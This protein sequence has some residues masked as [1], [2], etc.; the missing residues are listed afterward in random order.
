MGFNEHATCS[1]SNLTSKLQ[2]EHCTKAVLLKEEISS[3]D[4]PDKKLHNGM[5]HILH[6]SLII[7]IMVF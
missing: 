2:S 7:Q 6:Y 1:E 4:S 3:S 5:L